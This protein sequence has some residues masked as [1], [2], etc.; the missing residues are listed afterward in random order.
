MLTLEMAPNREAPLCLFGYFVKQNQAVWL[1][2]L[3]IPQLLNHR[4][5]LDLFQC[6]GFD[7]A[8][9]FAGDVDSRPTS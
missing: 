1:I 2:L 9:T 7:L 8:D 6:L 4:I 5:R 3:S